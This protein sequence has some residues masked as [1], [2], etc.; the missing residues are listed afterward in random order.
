MKAICLALAVLFSAPFCLAAT[1]DGATLYRDN[2]SQC[3]GAGGM[4]GSI[5]LGIAKRGAGGLMNGPDTPSA[6]GPGKMPIQGPKLVGKASDWTTELFERAVLKGVD[7]NGNPLSGEM[8][9]WGSS[10][11]SQDHGKLPTKSEVEAIQKY[12]QVL[13]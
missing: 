12:L 11:F 6:T 9:H 3:H 13:N 10:G 5:Q 2:C 1:P 4:G 7:D 8:P